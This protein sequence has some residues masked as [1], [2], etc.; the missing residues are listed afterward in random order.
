MNKF[1][2]YVGIFSCAVSVRGEEVAA[3]F[4]A[5]EDTPGSILFFLTR[6]KGKTDVMVVC[7]K[8]MEIVFA[9]K[10]V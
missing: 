5:G 10:L 1:T 6:V 3:L 7:K 8:V 9:N 2:A 4:T